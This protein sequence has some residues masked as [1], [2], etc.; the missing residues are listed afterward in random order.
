MM[1]EPEYARFAWGSPEMSFKAAVMDPKSI[2]YTSYSSPAAE[3]KV[4]NRLDAVEPIF[5][6]AEDVVAWVDAD[7]RD[8]AA[9]TNQQANHFAMSV[10][11]LP[12]AIFGP[13]LLTGV[14]ANGDIADL[15]EAWIAKIK[16]THAECFDPD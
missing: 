1:G 6:V 8:K 3:F 14:D 16:S 13:V 9:Q 7:G 12:Y 10:L 5:T 2:H 11:G 4:L 15:S